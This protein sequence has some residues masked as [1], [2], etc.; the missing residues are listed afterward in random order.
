MKYTLPSNRPEVRENLSDSVQRD[1][2][3]A[4]RLMNDLMRSIE[5][6]P[7]DARNGGLDDTYEFLEKVY[8]CKTR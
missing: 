2:R 7:A 4:F 8:R 3:L 6:L 1:R 5:R